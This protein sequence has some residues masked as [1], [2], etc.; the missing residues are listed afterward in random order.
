MAQRL[1]IEITADDR[2]AKSAIQSTNTQMGSMEQIAARVANSISRSFSGA[3]SGMQA[4][5]RQLVDQFG[6]PFDQIK[7]T[8]AS[9][10]DTLRDKLSAAL[11]QT[12]T[13]VQSSSGTF[14]SMKDSILNG[15]K[16]PMEAAAGGISKLL[17]V[18]GPVGVGLMVFGAIAA[19]TVGPL[20]DMTLA[21]GKAAENTMNMADRL[22]ISVNAMK[23][24]S[25][26]AEIAGVDVGALEGSTRIIAAA[27][28][29]SSGAG[30]KA[31]KALGS[32]G[33]ATREVT[34]EEREH[35][36]VLL[37]LLDHLST[38]EDGNKRVV[39]A[40][41]VL[42]RSSKELLPMIKNMEELKRVVAELK[43]GQ[44]TEDG[45]RALAKMDDEVDKLHLVWEKFKK[46]V[47]EKIAP[48]VIEVV[49]RVTKLFP[50]GTNFFISDSEWADAE[51]AKQA[52]KQGSSEWDMP[53]W[54][55]P[56]KLSI[57]HAAVN[58]DADDLSKEIANLKSDLQKQKDIYWSKDVAQG[59]RAAAANQISTIQ[60]QITEKT[61]ELD[62]IKKA[63]DSVKTAKQLHLDIQTKI[64]DLQ[65]QEV[66]G[67]ARLILERD[68][69]L[70]KLKEKHASQADYKALE[71]QFNKNIALEADKAWKDMNKL[72]TPLQKF[73]KLLM[74]STVEWIKINEEIRKAD[75]ATS[76]MRSEVGFAHLNQEGV[77]AE[78][79]RDAK[80][81]WIDVE[82]A[83]GPVAINRQVEL[84]SQRTQIEKDFQNELLDIQIEALKARA[85]IRKVEIAREVRDNASYSFIK[86]AQ[87][88]QERNAVVDALL[89][90]DIGTATARRDVTNNKSDINEQTS[91]LKLI[92]ETNKKIEASNKAVYD[93]LKQSASNVFD[94]LLSKSQS[95]W[96]AMANAFKTA[97]L[98][99]FK[100]IVTSQVSRQLTGLITG[101]R[102]SFA[103]EVKYG[104]TLGS[105]GGVIGSLGLNPPRFGQQTTTTV[106]GGGQTTATQAVQQAA[107]GGSPIQQASNIAK[108]SQSNW[109]KGLFGGGTG[110]GQKLS[111]AEM[112]QA[113]LVPG[114]TG[115][116]I[117]KDG[118]LFDTF[119]GAVIANKPGFWAASGHLGKAGPAAQGALFAGGSM[120]GMAG[121][122]RG[123]WMGVAETT[124][125]GAMIG[126]AIAPGLGTAIGAGVG[127]VAGLIRKTIKGSTENMKGRIL[128]LTGV[129]VRENNILKQA[130]EIAKSSF[131]G[132]YDLFIRSKQGQ[133]LIEL[134]AQSTGQKY[135]STFNAQQF[136]MVQSGGSLYEMASFTG[137]SSNNP[138]SNLPGLGFS[139]SMDQIQSGGMTTGPVPMTLQIDGPA[140]TALIRGETVNVIASPAGQQ[141]NL[142]AQRGS[143]NRT[144]SATMLFSPMT[145]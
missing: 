55:S 74:D 4:Q 98:T 94:A 75:E 22:G 103:P 136:N 24:L 67:A 87:V 28:E 54:D 29:D 143:V 69:E 27:L 73:N 58:R 41:Q 25:A 43:I 130:V 2:S 68:Q 57:K 102:P 37:D 42:G 135:R 33:I 127:F 39:I 137:G 34:G 5:T 120:L 40:N 123:G 144:E 49:T 79:Q 134:Y 88:I 30:A 82:E 23:Q 118:K 106:A 76:S 65:R 85:A 95:V 46:S 47:A 44:G 139:A 26:I 90:E 81:S 53:K 84:N 45:I 63:A 78:L 100:E 86:K 6:R 108:Q 1:T 131:G 17:A 16:S 18:M 116:A 114:M 96:Q 83:R 8:A 128:A 15:I 111:T 72:E 119:S 101:Q 50:S 61:N 91:R 60:A 92:T 124:A 105:I 13:D 107:T 9:T 138:L 48:I 21:A 142:S 12:K 31:A 70:A 38:I 129:N 7:Q 19:K 113:A 80:L 64:N 77:G 104:G 71:A 122:Q 132:N 10:G 62:N 109:F 51:A 125:G 121:L 20:L 66:E 35:G 112:S 99:V 145:R 117:T 59:P 133:D 93:H 110:V 3:F 56:L 14:A 140:T 115:V 32:L 89:A 126:T 52:S 36:K 97:F 141:A 11:K